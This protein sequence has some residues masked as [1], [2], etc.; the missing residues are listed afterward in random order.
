M[1]KQNNETTPDGEERIKKFFEKYG[2]LVKELEVDMV[3]YPMFV[4]DGEGGFKII[5][6][7]SPVDMKGRGVKSPFVVEE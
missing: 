6:Q 5:V 1:Q 2:E 4:P 3:N 7:S